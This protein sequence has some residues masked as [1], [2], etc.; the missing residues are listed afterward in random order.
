MDFRTRVP[1]KESLSR[2]EH[3][4]GVFLIGSCFVENIGSKLEWF[5]FKNLQNPTGII[6]HPTPIRKFIQRIGDNNY[7]KESDLL[8]TNDGWISLEAH[9]DVRRR[10]KEACL[11]ALNGA[12]KNSRKFIENSSFV[13]I[14]LGTAWGYKHETK[15]DIV[16]NCHKIRQKEFQKQLSSSQDVQNDLKLI[17]ESLDKINKEIRMILTVSPV[18]HLKDGMIENQQSKAHLISGLHEYLKFDELSDYF[19]S[20]EI[21]MDEL[22]DYRFYSEDM[23]HPNKT[24]VDY[25][26]KL[27][28]ENWMS[29]QIIGLN[30]EIDKIQKALYHRPREENSI[31]HRKFLTK[32][33]AKIEE[34]Q[35]N[36][37]EITFLSPYKY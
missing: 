6:F 1:V 27:F 2:I 29:S 14:S 24:A 8:E 20:Y 32:I 17:R 23:L 33:Q 28:S 5:R 26:W 4:S 21:L 30:K 35:N 36:H 22:R 31:E 25:I 19:P 16:A 15:Q 37:P 34:I 9:S 12:L 11:D 7:Y 13:V 3:T 18:R 10:T